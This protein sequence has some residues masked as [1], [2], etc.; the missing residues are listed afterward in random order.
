MRNE[1]SRLVR[2]TGLKILKRLFRPKLGQ[3]FDLKNIEFSAHRK[4]LFDWKQKPWFVVLFPNFSSLSNFSIGNGSR[5]VILKFWWS[6]ESE[7]SDIS[8][9]L[10]YFA[11]INNRNGADWK[12]FHHGDI[13]LFT[14][15][16]KMTFFICSF[17]KYKCSKSWNFDSVFEYRRIQGREPVAVIQTYKLLWYCLKS[18]TLTVTLRAGDF[19]PKRSKNEFWGTKHS[20]IS[21]IHP[22]TPLKF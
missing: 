13:D 12:H 21:K 15:G 16:R 20:W 1:I 22:M 5:V 8:N 14:I 10:F 17:T 2:S 18:A 6:A 19:S 3:V 11:W 4:K 7:N 9:S